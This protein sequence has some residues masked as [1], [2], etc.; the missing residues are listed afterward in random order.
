MS[1]RP[2]LDKLYTS[3]EKKLPENVIRIK[4]PEGIYRLVLSDSHATQESVSTVDGSDGVILEGDVIIFG[5]FNYSDPKIAKRAIETAARRDEQYKDII[6][7]CQQNDKPIYYTDLQY[8]KLIPFIQKILRGLEFGVAAN[9]LM[10]FG[11][12]I[13]KKPINRRD[14]LKLTAGAFL[15]TPTLEDFLFILDKDN[16]HHT[17]AVSAT[18]DRLG[19]VNEKMHPETHA[20][21]R[22]L[23]NCLMA[24]KW[25]TI[26]QIS[27]TSQTG[28]KPEI[29]QVVGAMHT[30]IEDA[31]NEDDSERIATIKQLLSVPGLE[32]DRKKIASIARV[33]YS[34]KTQTWV[35]TEYQD[36]LLKPLEK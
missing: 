26:M 5:D 21:I 9:L 15:A 3:Q 19:E 18:R 11:V 20:I 23:R 10:R 34:K 29:A 2:F 14:F 8:I 36:P 35:V 17:S 33:L 22:T 13:T 30:G 1:E 12:N 32:E 25:K 7:W 28:H 31:L 4:K 24:Q 27:A 6:L 16:N